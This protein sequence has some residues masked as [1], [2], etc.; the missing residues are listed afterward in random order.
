MVMTIKVVTGKARLNHVH[1]FEK[2]AIGGNALIA[3]GFAQVA[4]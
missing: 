3:A 2:F 4:E 1:L